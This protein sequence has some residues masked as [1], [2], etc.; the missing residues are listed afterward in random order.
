MVDRLSLRVEDSVLERYEDARFHGFRLSVAGPAAP[1]ASAPSR[2]KFHTLFTLLA[3]N[4]P[5]AGQFFTGKWEVITWSA[6]S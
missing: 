6:E 1:M 5:L 4:Q 2:G 3:D